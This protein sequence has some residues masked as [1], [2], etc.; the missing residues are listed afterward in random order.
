[1]VLMDFVTSW[2]TCSWTRFVTST[3]WRPLPHGRQS[4]SPATTGSAIRATRPSVEQ[5]RPF[6][7]AA[8]Q[9]TAAVFFRIKS[10][11]MR[12]RPHPSRQSL[13]NLENRFTG[14]STSA[15]GAGPRGG[16]ARRRADQDLTFDVAYTSALTRAQETLEIILTTTGKRPPVI[17]DQALNERHYG[18]LQASTRRTRRS[19][20]ARSR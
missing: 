7:T 12:P 11:P 9:M 17:R 10:R 6:Q 2:S 18:D 16:E 4:R 20:T 19:G 15:H 1:M 3:I 13:W 8:R 14:G 5:S